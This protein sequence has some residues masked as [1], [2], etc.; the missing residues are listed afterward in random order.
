VYKDGTVSKQ[1]QEQLD[2]LKQMI[3][4][5]ELE[6]VKPVLSDIFQ[7]MSHHQLNEVCEFFHL[8]E[9]P[10]HV[11]LWTEGDYGDSMLVVLEGDFN[12]NK[13]VDGQN[14]V[15][16]TATPGDLVGAIS[17]LGGENQRTSTLESLSPAKVLFVDM[18]GLD[19]L[20]KA[21]PKLATQLY[22]N[23]VCFL[24]NRLEQETQILYE[25]LSK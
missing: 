3:E 9:I 24:S 25:G 22:F 12:L 23:I 21:K 11:R 17:I 5:G 14:I 19:R 2:R 16:R 1:E 6:E 4:N 15:M 13:Q 7:D 20:Y 10:A 8:K 18:A